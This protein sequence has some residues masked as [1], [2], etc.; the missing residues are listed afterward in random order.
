MHDVLNKRIHLREYKIEIVH[1][2]KPSDQIACTNFAVDVLE[3]TGASFYF[4]R[5][6]CFSD[7]ATS[8]VYGVVNRY[9]CRLWNSQNSHVTCELERGSPKVNMWPGLMQDKLIWLFLFSEKTVNGRSYLNMLE[10]PQLPSQT[11]L[12]N[13]GAPPHLCH[14]IRNHLDREVAGRWI[15]RGEPIAWP[16]RS[17]DLTLDFFLRSYV[18]TFSIRLRSMTFNTWKPA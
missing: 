1:A 18:K 6:G 7:E 13:N 16:P 4:L 12:Q 10:L 2:R 9:N 3:R 11:I 14:H 17:P 8:H 5:Q 15:G